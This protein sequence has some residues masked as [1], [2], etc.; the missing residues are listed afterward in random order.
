MKNTTITHIEGLTFNKDGSF[1]RKNAYASF[2]P[3]GIKKGDLIVDYVAK[4]GDYEICLVIDTEDEDSPYGILS[5]NGKCF[6]KWTND[7]GLVAAIEAAEEWAFT[8]TGGI[9][10]GDWHNASDE[11][12]EVMSKQSGAGARRYSALRD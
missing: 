7:A 2:Y 9:S 12:R 5:S 3:S 1:Q 6:K 4:I 11:D 10:D 8:A